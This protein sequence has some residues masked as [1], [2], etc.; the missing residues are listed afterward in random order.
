MHQPKHMADFL[1]KC[2][3]GVPH[4]WQSNYFTHKNRF[5]LW[6]QFNIEDRS[7]LVPL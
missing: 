4:K 3:N 6:R 2:N 1:R 7:K 5:N